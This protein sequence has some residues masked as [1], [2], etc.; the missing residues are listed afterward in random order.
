MTKRLEGLKKFRE[1]E[2]P[3]CALCAESYE[4]EEKR[5]PLETSSALKLEGQ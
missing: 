4:N 5:K 1:Q 3:K 2:E